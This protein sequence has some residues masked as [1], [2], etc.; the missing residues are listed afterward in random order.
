MRAR[1]KERVGP[2]Q[3]DVSMHAH[4]AQDVPQ[5]NTHCTAGIINTEQFKGGLE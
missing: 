4:S 5:R 2:G 1:N 3:K